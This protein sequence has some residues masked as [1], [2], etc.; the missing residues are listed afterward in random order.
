[1]CVYTHIYIYIYLG[2][3]TNLLINARGIRTTHISLLFFY[4]RDTCFSSVRDKTYR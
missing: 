3:R 4:I 1:V 2:R